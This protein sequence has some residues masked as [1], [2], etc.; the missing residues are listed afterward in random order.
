MWAAVVLSVLAVL[1]LVYPTRFFVY[2]H[3][4]PASPDTVLDIA[5]VFVVLVPLFLT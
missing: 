5:I 2:G 4:D 1:T 3:E